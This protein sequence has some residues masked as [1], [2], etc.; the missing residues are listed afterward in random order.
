MF[1]SIIRGKMQILKLMLFF[2]IV[3]SASNL[4]GQ[5][6]SAQVLDNGNGS[7][8]QDIFH[9][10]L[11]DC[12]NDPWSNPESVFTFTYGTCTFEVHYA[13]RLACGTYCDLQIRSIHNL[14]ADPSC[15]TMSV[16]QLISIASVQLILHEMNGPKHHKD[17]CTP[18]NPNDCN[19]FW[20]VSNGACWNYSPLQNPVGGWQ[21]SWSSCYQ[22][23]CCLSTYEVCMDQYGQV[24]VTR[25]SQF[26]DFPCPT[27]LHCL[28]ACG[29]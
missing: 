24:T 4:Y 2:I 19:L 22:D 9:W 7:T 18:L 27:D 13:W 29:D 21:G 12:Q 6:K 20:R 16:Q 5:G 26:Q 10:C 17:H 11:P 8:T 14:S 15:A 1:Q 28:P 23:A 25:V 3:I